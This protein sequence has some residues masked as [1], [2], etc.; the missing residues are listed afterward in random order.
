MNI[1]E[2]FNELKSEVSR[3]T[4]VKFDDNLSEAEVLAQAQKFEPLTST[5]NDAIARRINALEDL[6]LNEFP[7]F[8]ET[9][10]GIEPG[11]KAEDLD[12]K[13]TDSVELTVKSAVR[14][15]ITPIKEQFANEIVSLKKLSEKKVIGTEID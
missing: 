4:G 2:L 3:I 9:L 15:A 1:Q 5:D 11:I 13:I 10:N 6:L 7:K 8:T 12:A 14:E